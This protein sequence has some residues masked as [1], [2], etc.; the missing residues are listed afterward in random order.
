[1]VVW[2]GVEV[3]HEVSLTLAIVVSGG[4]GEM[5][6]TSGVDTSVVDTRGVGI[7][8]LRIGCDGQEELKKMRAS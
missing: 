8:E 5:S 2:H 6:E 3:V 7:D 1:M 4:V